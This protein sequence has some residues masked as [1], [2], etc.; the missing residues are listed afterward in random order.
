M[1]GPVAVPRLSPARNNAQEDG[2]PAFTVIF[3]LLCPAILKWLSF[4][5]H[6]F[7]HVELTENRQR[8]HQES[9]S[10]CHRQTSAGKRKSS[11]AESAHTYSVF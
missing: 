11:L 10:H 6:Y 8:R 5:R 3:A 7:D 1:D 9:S 4:I 2:S